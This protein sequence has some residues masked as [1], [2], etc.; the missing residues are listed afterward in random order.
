MVQFNYGLEEN[1]LIRIL[2][3]GSNLPKSKR[4]ERLRLEILKSKY[5]NTNSLLGVKVIESYLKDKFTLLVLGQEQF[6]KTRY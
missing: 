4:N 6:E 1:Y 2:L 5:L 3:H